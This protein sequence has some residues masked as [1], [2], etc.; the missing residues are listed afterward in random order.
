MTMFGVKLKKIFRENLLI[1]LGIPLLAWCISA[2]WY[3]L[4]LIQGQS[5]YPTYRHLQV[6]LLNKHEKDYHVGNVVAFTCD[7]L[8]TVLV[9]RIAAGPG[10]T[11]VI[12]DSDLLVNG[13]QSKYYPEEDMFSYTGLLSDEILLAEGEYF[14]LGDNSDESIDSRYPEVGILCQEDILG[15]ICGG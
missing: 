2:N 6:V 13:I 5:M 15:V 12:R 8:S 1:W 14:V 10:D 3:Q 9:K 7:G 11:I 4:M